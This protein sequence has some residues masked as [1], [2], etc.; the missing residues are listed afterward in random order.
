MRQPY[1]LITLLDSRAESML[2]NTSSTVRLDSS[3]AATQRERNGS[4]LRRLL[5]VLLVKDDA[6]Q[7]LLQ[8]FVSTALLVTVLSPYAA[9]RAEHVTQLWLPLLD[10]STAAQKQW[11][12]FR[13]RGGRD[14]ATGARS[15]AI[16]PQRWTL[17]DRT[18]GELVA[19]LMQMLRRFDLNALP[20]DP[21]DEAADDPT[22]A[23]PVAAAAPEAAE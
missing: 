21:A 2:L 13:R 16:D 18:F 9:V 3:A 17:C 20:E 12:G 8:R 15:A 11:D 22:A 19:S 1:W 5:L 14:G 4:A 6:V 23:T 10:P 7:Q